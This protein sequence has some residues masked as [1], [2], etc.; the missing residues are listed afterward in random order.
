MPNKKNSRLDKINKIA[1]ALNPFKIGMGPKKISKPK[2]AKKGKP[3]RKKRGGVSME[4][5]RTFKPGKRATLKPKLKR[6]P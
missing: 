3:K 2:A 4:K 5:Q 6:R 1:H